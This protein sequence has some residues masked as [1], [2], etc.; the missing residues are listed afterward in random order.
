MFL[1]GVSTFALLGACFAAIPSISYY[2]E[3][4][5]NVFYM[6]NCFFVG[7]IMGYLSLGFL[8]DINGRLF[9]FNFGLH[10]LPIC[11]VCLVLSSNMGLCYTNVIAAS[12]LLSGIYISTR[13]YFVEYSFVETRG[14]SYFT[15]TIAYYSST[16][17]PLLLFMLDPPL[18]FSMDTLKFLAVFAT[19]CLVMFQLSQV[20][21]PSLRFLLYQR[22]RVGAY[23]RHIFTLNAIQHEKDYKVPKKVHARKLIEF[24]DLKEALTTPSE[25]IQIRKKTLKLVSNQYLKKTLCLLL[26]SIVVWTNMLLSQFLLLNV[27]INYAANHVIPFPKH[28]VNQ[29]V[30]ISYLTPEMK[31]LTTVHVV[32]L[33]VSPVLLLLILR[34]LSDRVK[35][36]S[37]LSSLILAHAVLL[38]IMYT[39]IH[40]SSITTTT[41]LMTVFIC[42][43]LALSSASSILLELIILE[44]LPTKMRAV[45][46]S[47]FKT[48]A[49]I[50]FMI[51]FDLSM[52]SKDHFITTNA[53]LL[54]VI[55]YP[56]GK[57]S[58]QC[59]KPMLEFASPP[60]DTT[61]DV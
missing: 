61:N 33:C 60:S 1:V 14:K 39:V 10:L 15:L 36:T 29:L 40:S 9:M 57:I 19:L 55:L 7:Q 58:D 42:L 8:V 5:V 34:P 56:I 46:F 4:H 26:I 18:L 41:T 43:M 53:I 45:G 47:V 52:V 37:M 48:V 51:L 20:L 11:I 17:L 32:A 6:Y 30:P 44:N 16:A 38:C 25:I 22:Q 49:M 13:V 21:H 50:S 3:Q 24:M 23:L 35:R 12:I 27:I 28:L 59:K 31:A 54:L 2:K